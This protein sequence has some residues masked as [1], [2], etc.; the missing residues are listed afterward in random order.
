MGDTASGAFSHNKGSN[1]PIIPNV[2]ASV[3]GCDVPA[4]AR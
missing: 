3:P 4:P 1:S 2:I